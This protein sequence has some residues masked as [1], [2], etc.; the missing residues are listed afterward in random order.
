M[1]LP[2]LVL[3]ARHLDVSASCNFYRLGVPEPAQGGILLG[4]WGLLQEIN[5]L[6]FHVHECLPNLK[7][8]IMIV[9]VN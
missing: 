5:L 4:F 1:Y 2:S 6:N 9:H 7:G 3:K 8:I